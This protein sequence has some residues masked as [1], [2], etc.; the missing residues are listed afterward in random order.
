VAK[1]QARSTSRHQGCRRLSEP[2]DK[3]T[4]DRLGE[5]SNA[6]RARVE[7]ALEARR[8]RFEGQGL[9]CNADVGV[10]EVREFCGVFGSGRA[11]RPARARQ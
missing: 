7:K 5:P 9:T 3:L 2:I 1:P 6:I 4:D 10:S 8:I 11:R